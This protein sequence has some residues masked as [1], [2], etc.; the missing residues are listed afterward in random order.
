VL[1]GKSVYNI[2]DGNQSVCVFRDNLSL[3]IAKTLTIQATIHPL[4]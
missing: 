1:S 4:S 2:V 3:T